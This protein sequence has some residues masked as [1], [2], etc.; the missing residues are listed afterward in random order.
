MDRGRRRRTSPCSADTA[1]QLQL[2]AILI[3]IFDVRDRLCDLFFA[4]AVQ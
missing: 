3:A 2:L 1:H 4:L